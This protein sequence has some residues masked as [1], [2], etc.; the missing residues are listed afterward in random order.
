MGVDRRKRGAVANVALA[1]GY[2]SLSEKAIGKILPELRKG[3]V[4]SDAVLAARDTLITPTFATPRPTTR[5]LTT[6]L[7]CR[8]MQWART[9]EER[10]ET[11]RRTGTLWAHRQPDGAYRA[12]PVAPRGERHYRDVRETPGDCG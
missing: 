12:E 8:A 5:C 11:G 10:R 4:F 7:C 1:P 2:G 3:R 9:Y 6:G